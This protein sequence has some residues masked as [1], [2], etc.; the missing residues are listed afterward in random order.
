MRWRPQKFRLRHAFGLLILILLV[1]AIVGRMYLPVWLKDYVNN[2]LN[3]IKGYRGGVEA[4]D[5]HLYRGAYTIRGLKLNKINAGVPV[6]F[7]SIASTDLSLQWGALFQGRVVSD[8]H[9]SQ[10]QINFAVGKSGAEQYGKETD[11]TVPIKNLM[12]IDIN[13]VEIQRG[14]ISYRDFESSPPV[15]LFITDISGTMNNLRNVDE[16]G[17]ALPSPIDFRGNSIGGGKLGIKGRVNALK[18]E[19]DMDLDGKLEG[20]DLKAFNDFSSAYAGIIFKEGSM[21]LY[22]EFV[23]K[24]GQVSGYVKP[25][26]RNLSVDKVPEDGNPFVVIWSTLA[27]IVLEILENQPRDQFASKVPLSGSLDSIQ[28][29][30]WPALG[31]V[32]RNA[33]VQAFEKGTDDEITFGKNPEKKRDSSPESEESPPYPSMKDDR[34]LQ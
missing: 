1:T 32:F 18:K 28:T 15:D 23:V 29:Q 7:L 25:I 20:A 10:P 2:E 12:P 9:L 16:K 34:R 5:V 24:D 6:P 21:D 11:W 27:A 33:F 31:A 26:V 8:V 14:K 19:T 30:F 3:N 17:S 22:S 4:I 13:V